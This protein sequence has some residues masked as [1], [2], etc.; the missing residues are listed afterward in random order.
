MSLHR[1]TQPVPW[2]EERVSADPFDGADADRLFVFVPAI[3]SVG[4]VFSI[5]TLL[6]DGF[7]WSGNRTRERRTAIAAES[8]VTDLIGDQRPD[9]NALGVLS[10]PSYLVTAVTLVAMALYV[11]I[12]SVANF[13]NEEGYVRDIG[14]LLAL[15]LGLAVLLGFLAAVSLA[16]YWSW[17]FPPDWTMGALRTAPLTVTPGREGIGPTW[18]RT[19]SVVAALVATGIITLLVTAAR[20]VAQA[21]DQPVLDWLV[22]MTWLERLGAVDVF[23][24]TAISIGFVVL[25][26]LSAFRCRVMAAVYPV[27]FIVSLTFGEVIRDI[28]ER[29]RPTGLGDPESFPSGHM[30]QAVFIAGLVPVA[31]SVLTSDRRALVIG[32]LFFVAAVVAT[33]LRRIHVR[34]HW[35][36]DVVAGV[37]FGLAIVLTAQWALEHRSWHRSCSTCPWSPHPSPTHW[38][39]PVLDIRP[40]TA[41]LCGFVGSGLAL[42]AAGALALTTFTIGIPSDPEGAGF[43]SEI[44]EPVQ[45]S[46]AALMGVAGVLALRWKAVAAF[47]MAF[48]ATGLGLFASVEY[49]PWVAVSLTAALMVPAVITWFAWQPHETIGSVAV[50]AAVTVTLLTAAAVGS[51]AVYAHYFGPT[52]PESA[53][54][55]VEFAEADWLWLGGVRPDEATVVAGGLDDGADVEVLYWAAG[56]GSA[57]SATGTADGDGIARF[58]LVGLSPD[59]RYAYVVDETPV[60][61]AVVDEAADF[62]DVPSADGAFST[63]P[64]GAHSFVVVAGSC[65]RS[66]SNGAVFDAMVGEDPDLYLALGDLHYANLESDSPS[67]HLAQYGRALRQP[68]QSA[69]FR[70]VPTA[71]VWDDHDYGPNDADSTSPARIAVSTAYRRAVPHHGVDPDPDA[72]I[73]QAFTVGRVRFVMTDT[74]SQRDDRTMLG[75]EQLEWFIDEV[76]T[77]SRSHAL[78]VWANPTPWISSAGADDWSGYAEERR[79]IADAISGAGVEN[80]VMVS[81]DAHMVAID[82]GTNSGYAT[83]GGGGFPVL[84]AAALDRP[85]SLKGGPY[86]EGAFPGSGQYGRIEITDQ[87]GDTVGVRLSGHNW[88]GTDLVRLDLEFDVPPG[89]TSAPG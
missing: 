64:V 33:G 12:G 9:P 31:I 26:G 24:S 5:V 23:G 52:H 46:L 11:T 55:D 79:A 17:P 82:D 28:V 30:I 16:V 51:T 78:V 19:A 48:A 53:A 69:L 20:H 36:I 47:M 56:G 63:P 18:T 29:P 27:A 54:A 57:R 21:I 37:V 66:G 70:S 80:L 61:D 3:M 38:G 40:R 14:W 88:Q 85:G 44:S 84:H 72:S 60:D 50:L 76:I 13:V 71:Y 67:D 73:A 39:D 42:A 45:I 43:G 35:P 10:R 65:A 41:R 15:S 62:A 77:S 4:L 25:I 68:G 6:R 89:A 49:R 34:E 59:T 86:S 8:V 7:R 75:P 2:P 58:R 83:D 74:R 87:G 81:G 22:E 32:R 1:P